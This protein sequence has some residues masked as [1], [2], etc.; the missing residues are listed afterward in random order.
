MNDN[1]LVTLEIIYWL[2]FPSLPNNLPKCK[3]QILWVSTE[4]NVT[5]MF[6]KRISY[7]K[8]LQYEVAKFRN[9]KPGET[10]SVKSK[11]K[12]RLQMRKVI[13]AKPTS[14]K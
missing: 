9:T 13:I 10:R 6:V 12:Y 5:I 14:S 7:R 11:A 3:T 2:E 4:S 1:S 8:L